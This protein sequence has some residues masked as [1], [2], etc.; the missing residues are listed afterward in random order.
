MNYGILN[1]NDFGVPQ[2]R[3]RA[4]FIC[5]KSKDIALPI[6][7]DE[8]VTIRDAISDLAYLNSAQG[9]FESDYQMKADS[10]YQKK[11]RANSNKLYN[12]QATAHS[13]V[14]LEK[15]A[16]IPPEK[17]KEYLPDE[18]KGNQKFNT[19]WGRLVWNGVSPTI[20]TRFDAPSNGTNSHPELNRSITP[21]EAARIQSFS[22]DFIFYGGKRSVGRQIG[23]AVPPLLAKGIADKI[24]E[25]YEDGKNDI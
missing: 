16:M 19:T 4:I 21:R 25:M 6:G 14:A 1:A 9:S 10:E 7:N 5:S 3:E 11:M 13:K 8:G 24:W 2:S 22:D 20:D 15:L 17:G 23:N 12:H 18:L